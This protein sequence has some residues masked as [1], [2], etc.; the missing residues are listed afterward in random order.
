[1]VVQRRGGLTLVEVIVVV[2]II[3]GLIALLLPAIS[4]ARE[5]ARRL[6]CGSNLKQIGL[7][8]LNY[9][10]VHGSFPPGWVALDRSP[11]KGAFFGWQTFILPYVEEMALYDRIDFNAIPITANS[12]DGSI[13]KLTGSALSVYRCASDPTPTQNP[14]RSG[15]ATSNYSAIFGSQALPRVLPDRMGL[16]MPGAAPTPERSDGLFCA[17]SRI[18]FAS[19]FDGLANTAMVAE[20]GL[21]SGSGIWLGVVQ[22]QFENDQVTDCSFRSPIN[23]S[24]SSMSSAHPG[25][26]NVLLA[27]GVLEFVSEQIDSS[28]DGKSQ[29]LFQSLCDRGGSDGIDDTRASEEKPADDEMPPVEL[30]A[31]SAE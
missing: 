4:A 7:A 17:N 9:H 24:Y 12:T 30:K 31:R 3:A 21:G 22:N 18:N 10:D 5:A 15:F 1:M 27:D 19:V 26:V 28:Q 13:E 29:G 6:Q 2:V 23:R 8:L 14:L 25:G 11:E 16:W 20:R